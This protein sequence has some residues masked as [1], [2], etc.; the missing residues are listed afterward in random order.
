MMVSP[1]PGRERPGRVCLDDAG[2][3]QGGVTTARTTDT[4]Y[5][6]NMVFVPQ[7]IEMPL[8]QFVAVV[9]VAAN[10]LL[11]I[12]RIR[13]PDEND[14]AIVQADLLG[15]GEIPVGYIVADGRR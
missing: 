5:L 6:A 15:I 11:E 2:E 13:L 4:I 3:I 9:N 1:A 10:A 8:H 7:Q 12:V 14:V